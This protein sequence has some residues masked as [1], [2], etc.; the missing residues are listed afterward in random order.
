MLTKKAVSLAPD[1]K[2]SV[3]NT[4]YYL[5]KAFVFLNFGEPDLSHLTRSLSKIVCRGQE[6]PTYSNDTLRPDFQANSRP[7]IF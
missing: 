2:K 4:H 1:L 5:Q 3:P 7:R 6:G